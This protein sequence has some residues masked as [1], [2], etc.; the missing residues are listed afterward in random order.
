VELLESAK[1]KGHGTIDM[2]LNG[3]DLLVDC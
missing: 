3:T 2:P 1:A